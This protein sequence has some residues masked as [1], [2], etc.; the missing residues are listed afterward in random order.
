MEI[1]YQRV[2]NQRRS[3]ESFWLPFYINKP[4]A[5]YFLL[6]FIFL[7]VLGSYLWTTLLDTTSNVLQSRRGKFPLNCSS[8]NNTRTCPVN[9]YPADYKFVNDNP[10]SSSPKCPHYFHWIH[11]DLKPWRKTG[12]TE[13]MVERGN[14]TANF[15]LVVL[16]GRAYVETYEKGFQTR[17]VFTLWG[18][19]QLLRRYPGKIP[20]LDM[21]FDC[22]DWPVVRSSDF[23][24]ENAVAPPPLFRYC[25]DNETLDIVF[26]DWSFWGW[27]E[28]NIKPWQD[29]LKDLDKGNKMQRWLNREPYAYWKGN[30]EVA[31]KRMELVKCNVTENQESN[32]RIYVQD[33]KEEIKQGFKH[34]DLG[35]QCHHRYKIYIEGSA[36]SVSEKYIL[37]C[38]SVSLLVT[39]HYYDF[40]SRSLLPL[41][42][43]WP[44]NE[45]DKCGSIK[46][47]VDWGNKYKKKVQ[48]IGRKASDF[49]QEDL[50]MEYV[51]DYMFHLLNEYAKLLKYKPRVPKNASE[52]C[53]E[54]MA[55]PAEGTE[56]KLMMESMVNWP[57]DESP[58][59]MPIP[60]NKLTLDSY[61]KRKQNS[62]KEVRTLE[63]DYL[64]EQRVKTKILG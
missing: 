35:N 22:V 59:K 12:I 33:W 5:K 42:H 34:S 47:A 20:D 52:L 8:G 55:C 45:D 14:R 48:R 37:A 16:N 3:I 39:P 38:D 49:I 9:Y 57:I 64:R 6:F 41:V 18:I 30:P 60:F 31:E 61:H 54:I 27:A 2:G 25:G 26:P 21:M 62:I 56:K 36:W 44:I 40:F 32:A 63:R 46:F 10:S 28:I 11:E 51:Y 29:L 1:G 23:A 13:E 43:Y 58:C 4:F 17:D 15:R 7:L 24:G 50:R 53:S 19:L